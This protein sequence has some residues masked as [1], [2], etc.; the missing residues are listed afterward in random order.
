[1]LPVFA[2]LQRHAPYLSVSYVCTI[3]DPSS[4][5]LLWE[6]V[7]RICNQPLA[8]TR[9]IKTENSPLFFNAPHLCFDSVLPHNTCQDCTCLVRLSQQHC[10]CCYSGRHK[11]GQW[12]LLIYITCKRICTR[13]PRPA[14][15]CRCEN[16]GRNGSYCSPIR[17]V[18]SK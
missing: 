5:L 12:G 6:K 9:L 2:L 4:L 14:V 3:T 16:R 17:A 10:V 18:V 7:E 15:V 11:G 8:L 13:K 1:M